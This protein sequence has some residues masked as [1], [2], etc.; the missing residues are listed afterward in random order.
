M[1]KRYL[2][3]FIAS[4][5]IFEALLYCYNKLN[6]DKQASCPVFYAA[7]E[8]SI[9]NGYSYILIDA[10]DWCKDCIA[11]EELYKANYGQSISHAL[12]ETGGFRVILKSNNWDS[13]SPEIKE[14]LTLCKITNVPSIV[15]FNKE[16]FS[17]E[18][19]ISEIA[20]TLFCATQQ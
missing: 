1:L 11:L 20:A 19:D 15:V 3:W 16:T 10:P 7:K 14:L 5:F 6:T 4:I 2:I 9:V 17:V 12:K 8:A 13:N 18:T